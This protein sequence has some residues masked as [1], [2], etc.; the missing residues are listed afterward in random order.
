VAAMNRGAGT[1]NISGVGTVTFSRC[2]INQITSRLATVQPLRHRSW[3]DLS[4]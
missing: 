1:N 4:F 3:A 2:V